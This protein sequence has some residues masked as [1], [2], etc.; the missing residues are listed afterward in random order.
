VPAFDSGRAAAPDDGARVLDNGRAVCER[1]TGRWAKSL[2]PTRLAERVREAR[3]HRRPMM[4]PL[5][6]PVP[7]LTPP[8]HAL[9][10]LAF[11]CAALGVLYVP[12]YIPSTHVLDHAD[13]CATAS[14]CDLPTES[15][16][17]A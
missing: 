5:M 2:P 17:S 11:T 14:Y 6:F 7:G 4:L 3:C 9:L 8:D 15:A 13:Q 12:T 1:G 16:S 10:F